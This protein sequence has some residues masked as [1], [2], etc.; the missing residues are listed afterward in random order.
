MKYSIGIVTFENRFESYFKPLI[1]K[2][3]SSR[4]DI[5]ITVCI[6]GQYKKIAGTY[7]SVYTNSVGC[8]STAT[9]TL[10]VNPSYNQSQTAS[11]CPGDSILFGG[12]YY[13][14]AGTYTNAGQTSLGCDSIVVLNLSV[15]P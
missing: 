10:S 13:S 14:T 3:K 6:N 7:S 9:T 11:I 1:E 8:D 5:E 12:N 15:F 2:I 4:P